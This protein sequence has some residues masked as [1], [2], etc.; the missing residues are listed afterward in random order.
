MAAC[1][2]VA[3]SCSV[4]R[5]RWAWRTGCRAHWAG[6]SLC[7][8]LLNAQPSSEAAKGSASVP[9]SSSGVP[10]PAIVKPR[11]STVTVQVVRFL[12][13][14]WKTWTELLAPC[15]SPCQGCCWCL[16]REPGDGAALDLSP[17]ALPLPSNISFKKC[18]K[19]RS[20]WDTKNMKAPDLTPKLPF[21]F[22]FTL[23]TAEIMYAV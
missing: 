19:L 20:T 10:L 3:F 11:G 4:Q 23:Q 17:Y 6:D 7:V 18:L 21:M 13:P 16:G 9:A 2:R 22:E 1:P 14:T 8:Q 5:H 15:W 12:S